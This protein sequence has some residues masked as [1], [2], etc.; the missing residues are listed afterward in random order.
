MDR[1][2]DRQ[3]DIYKNKTYFCISGRTDLEQIN[4]GGC[5]RNRRNNKLV[6]YL[7]SY[8]IKKHKYR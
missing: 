8:S 5:P 6:S 1:Y 7:F 4:K 2:V 3:T